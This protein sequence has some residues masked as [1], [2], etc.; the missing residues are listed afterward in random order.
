M[1]KSEIFLNENVSQVIH[2]MNGISILLKK[3]S[4]TSFLEVWEK[5]FEL[6]N[7]VN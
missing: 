1:T 2:I 7:I 3:P 6:S 5:L 4:S